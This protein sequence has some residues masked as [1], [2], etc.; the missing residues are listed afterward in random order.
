MNEPSPELVLLTSA[1]I[2][3]YLHEQAN[4]PKSFIDEYYV[5]KLLKLEI[6][7]SVANGRLMSDAEISDRALTI[8][9][10][11]INS[12]IMLK[13]RHEKDVQVIPRPFDKGYETFDHTTWGT[14]IPRGNL[15]MRQRRQVQEL[16]DR[17]DVYERPEFSVYLDKISKS[18]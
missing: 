10:K 17:M 7:N 8:T 2:N 4:S 11:R 15:V 18:K 6:Q 12:S 16:P 13:K 9:A 1:K 5:Y 3:K 14:P